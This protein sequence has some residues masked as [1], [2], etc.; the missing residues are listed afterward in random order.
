MAALT[1]TNKSYTGSKCVFVVGP[2][3]SGKSA[4]ALQQ[5]EKYNG[6]IVNIDSIQL[7]KDLIIGSAAPSEKEKVRAPH[8]LYSYV[9]APKEMTAADYVKDFYQLLETNI[10]FPLFIVGGSG[11]YIQA[12]E[13]GMFD[14]NPIPEEFRKGIEDE[15]AFEG[16]E[17]LYAELK[18][19]DPN[20]KIHINDHYRLVRAIEIIRYAGGTPSQLKLAETNKNE[21]PFEYIKVGFDFE[22]SEFEKRVILRTRKMIEDGIIEETKKFY[23]L[24]MTEWSPLQSVGYKETLE[25]LHSAKNKDWLF[26]AINQSTMQLIKKQK[27][28]FKRDSSILWS[29]QEQL[30]KQF[31][32]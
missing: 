29:N 3:A 30:L 22:K 14:V 21:F 15:L 18:K 26:E 6:S 8:Y 4:W 25:F 5:A 13:K 23:D 2:T 17:K 20:S 27:T 31:I 7:Y 9:A 19:K 11:F 32:S 28:W 16:P 12:L 24:N 10:K 1:E